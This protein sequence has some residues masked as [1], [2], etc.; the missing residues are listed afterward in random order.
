MTEQQLKD[1]D[2]RYGLQ[3]DAKMDK[4]ERQASE[5]WRSLETNERIRRKDN[6]VN[7]GD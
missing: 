5:Q 1:Y 4:A 6:T 2:E 7:E 3:E